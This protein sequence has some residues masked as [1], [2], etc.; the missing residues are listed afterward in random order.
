[1]PPLCR[2][3]CQVPCVT[4]HLAPIS[5]AVVLPTVHAETNVRKE[6]VKVVQM[7]PFKHTVDDGLDARKAC[8]I[9]CTC[10]LTYAGGV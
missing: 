5:A 10:Q 7:G 2:T 4:H 1:M 8:H 6:L 9:H 3:S